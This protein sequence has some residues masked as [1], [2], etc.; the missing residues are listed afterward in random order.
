MNIIVGS[1]LML[2]HDKNI[3]EALVVQLC[4]T[5]FDI[6]NLSKLNVFQLNQIFIIL[7]WLTLDYFTLANAGLL[8][9]G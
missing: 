2:A 3:V 7:L 9:S 8:Y 1:S 5:A 6:F 4:W